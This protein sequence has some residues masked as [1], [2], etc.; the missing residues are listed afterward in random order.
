VSTEVE[1][2][3]ATGR[4]RNRRSQ[5]V[6]VAAVVLL[7]FGVITYRLFVAPVTDDPEPADAIV[8]LGGDGPREDRAIELL[9]EGWADTAVFSAAWDHVNDVWGT[10]VC[11]RPLP[12]EVVCFEPEPDTTQGEM[13]AIAAMA[14]ERGWDDLLVVTSNDQ[15]T[16]ARMLLDRCWSGEASFVGVAPPK[17]V[18]RAVYEWGAT[19]KALTLKRGC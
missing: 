3:P 17:P 13:R 5:V 8:A 2:I 1:E 16:R 9:E 10:K 11:R 14:E 15:I 6:A 19:L 7:L 4:G 18:F 12:G